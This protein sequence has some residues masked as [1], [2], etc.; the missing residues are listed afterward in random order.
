MQIVEVRAEQKTLRERCISPGQVA[1]KPWLVSS[2]NTPVMESDPLMAAAR[3]SLAQGQ[4]VH[5]LFAN[6]ILITI[7]P[8]IMYIFFQKQIVAGLTSGA[9]K[10]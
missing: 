8:R 1:S 3:S 5:R 4:C 7:P 9:V 10:G 2:A 6:V